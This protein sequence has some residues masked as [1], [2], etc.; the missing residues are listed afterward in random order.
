MYVYCVYVTQVDMDD[1]I[2]S[3]TLLLSYSITSGALG[4]PDLFLPYSV[5]TLA[6][7]NTTILIIT[8]LLLN[9]DQPINQLIH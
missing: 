9:S 8:H 4:S 3:Y 6:L 2:W 5:I 1:R 7:H